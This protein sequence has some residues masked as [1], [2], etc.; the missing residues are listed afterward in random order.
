MEL[1]TLR[2]LYIHELK[3]LYSAEKQLVKALPKAAKAAK[4]PELR[5][6]IE[7]H[8]EQTIEHV[9]RLEMLLEGLGESTRAPKCKGMEGLIAESE[10]FLGEEPGE[11]VIDAGIIAG[12]QKIEHYEIAGYGC[13]RSYAELLG[14]DEAVA[15]LQTTLDEEAATDRKLTELGMSL[16][17]I[18]ARQAGDGGSRTRR[19]GSAAGEPGNGGKRGSSARGRSRSR[20]G[21]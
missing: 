15:I 20:R 9:N 13:V 5:A 14:E 10:H 19:G 18:D 1:E 2:D 12:A 4:H 8:L 17:N 16:V 3:D 7:E 11:D 21:R 6:G